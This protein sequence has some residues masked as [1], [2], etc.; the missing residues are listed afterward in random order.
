MMN[1]FAGHIWKKCGGGEMLYARSVMPQNLINLET[2]KHIV[3][4]I[5]LAG[6]TLL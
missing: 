2:V 5:K 3:V 4:R 6:K 1:R